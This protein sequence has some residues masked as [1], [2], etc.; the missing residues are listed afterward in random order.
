MLRCNSSC[1]LLQ[2]Y[3]CYTPYTR[4]TET[5]LLKWP[6]N[7]DVKGRVLLKRGG[8]RGRVRGRVQPPSPRAGAEFWSAQKKNFALNGPAPKVKGQVFV[9]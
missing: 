7:K 4:G 5:K 8:W 3:S 1:G 6:A 9:G 2:I